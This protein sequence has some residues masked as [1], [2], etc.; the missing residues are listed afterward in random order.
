ML[1]SHPRDG[2]DVVR[3][4]QVSFGL[5]CALGVRDIRSEPTISN[6]PLLTIM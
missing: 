3:A 5:Q 2:R 6:Y 1:G 4:Q